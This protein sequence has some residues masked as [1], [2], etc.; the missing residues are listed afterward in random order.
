MWGRRI[1]NKDE[2]LDWDQ[3]KIRE[4]RGKEDLE[5]FSSFSSF[6]PWP[7]MSFLVE[8]KN[9]AKPTSI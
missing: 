7:K 9:N 8:R 6:S 1:L 3:R 2:L 4:Y 5:R